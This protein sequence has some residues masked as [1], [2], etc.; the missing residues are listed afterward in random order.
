GCSGFVHETLAARVA[1]RSFLAV[2][3][4]FL[5]KARHVRVA[6]GLTVRR[7]DP[8]AGIAE[9]DAQDI[10]FGRCILSAGH[11]S[12]PVLE[13]MTHGLQLPLGQPVKGQAVLLK[14]DVDPDLSVIFRGGLYIV[15]HEGGMVA[16]GSTS[17]D[18]FDD[19]SATDSQLDALLAAA[20]DLAP[21][22]ADA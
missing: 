22:L 15:P 9:S 2:L 6:E 18:R 5:R 17:E 1:P 3:D 21:A 11:E 10:R 13:G 16:V 19:P 4:A 7:I 14:A 12:F 20:R 8:A